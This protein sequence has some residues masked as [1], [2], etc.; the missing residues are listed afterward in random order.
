MNIG[1]LRHQVVFQAPQTTRGKD[2]SLNITYVGSVNVWAHVSEKGQ[3]ESE[4]STKQTV[5]S[6]IDI[7]VRYNTVTA[8]VN[9][10]YEVVWRGKSYNITSTTVDEKR[11]SITI[12]ATQ[13][14]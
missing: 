10:T 1:K 3:T 4:Q 12:Q 9:T 2:G 8:A 11:E 5:A 7:L 13:T 6:N 14:K